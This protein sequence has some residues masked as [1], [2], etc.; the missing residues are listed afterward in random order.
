MA[1]RLAIPQ[2]TLYNFIRLGE[3]DDAVIAAF[4]DKASLKAVHANRLA[5]QDRD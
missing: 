2:T 5:S 4:P 3:L 1:D